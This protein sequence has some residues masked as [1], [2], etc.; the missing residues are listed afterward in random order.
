MKRFKDKVIVITGGASG[1]GKSA[2][3]KFLNDGATVVIWDVNKEQGQSTLAEARNNGS[4][5]DFMKVNTTNPEEVEQATSATIEKFGKIDVLIN[6]AG[7]TRD[8]TIKKITYSEWQQVIDVNLTGVFNCTRSIIPRMIDKSYGRI[9]NTSSV[10]GLYG[11]FG[12]VN[13]AATKSGVIGMTKTLAKEL[14]KHNITVN[15]VA[16]GFIATEMVKTIPEKVINLMIDKTPLKRL[17]TPE[18]VANTYAFLASD[19]AAFISGAVISVDG[20]VTI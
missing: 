5:V 16:P 3:N 9:I 6:N 20:A 14:G 7:I 8:A 17:G 4:I 11:N 15:A 1:I 19:E 2:V 10:V 13:Y 12:Q 18:D